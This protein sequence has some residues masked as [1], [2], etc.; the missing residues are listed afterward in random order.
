[1]DYSA[2][3]KTLGEMRKIFNRNAGRKALMKL[4]S[5]RYSDQCFHLMRP[6]RTDALV[7]LDQLTRQGGFCTALGLNEKSPIPGMTEKQIQTS[8]LRI[9]A[10]LKASEGRGVC[11]TVTE[12]CDPHESSSEASGEGSDRSSRR[13][14]LEPHGLP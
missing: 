7:I 5:R 10:D 2:V 12:V 1:M 4:A 9:L 8:C 13:Q 11:E 14:H 6:G 3:E